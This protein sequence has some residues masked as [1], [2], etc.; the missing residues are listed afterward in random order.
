M[1]ADVVAEKAI[2]GVL[3][4]EI[5]I[6]VPE[7]MSLLSHVVRSLTPWIRHIVLNVITNL[8]VNKSGRENIN[9]ILS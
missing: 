7:E 5:V 9:R 3:R 1:E 6:T 4:D 8:A 2:D